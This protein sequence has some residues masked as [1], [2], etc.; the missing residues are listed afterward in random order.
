MSRAVGL[1]AVVAVM[2]VSLLYYRFVF[3]RRDRT[4]KV[5]G[6]QAAVDG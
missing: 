2:L 1:I 5:L 6:V 3:D 4:W